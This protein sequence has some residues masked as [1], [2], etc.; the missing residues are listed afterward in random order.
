[1]C[2]L[3]HP[4][5]SSAMFLAVARAMYYYYKDLSPKLGVLLPV[6]LPLRRSKYFALLNYFEFFSVLSDTQGC[7]VVRGSIQ[8]AVLDAKH[9][10]VHM[11]L[12]QWLPLMEIFGVFLGR[13]YF[14]SLQDYA[15]K[16]SMYVNL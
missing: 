6:S 13:R 1:M 12:C 5:I 2:F 14:F 7:D 16:D 4:I 11:S 10:G 9:V 3:N 8:G 15:I